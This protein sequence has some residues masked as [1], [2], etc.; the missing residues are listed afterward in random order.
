MVIELTHMAPTGEAIGKHDGQVIFVPYGVPGDVIEI[1]IFHKRRNFARARITEILRPSSHRVIPPCRFFGSCGGCEWQH[2]DYEQQLIYKANAVKEQFTRIG[3][4]P[5]VTV[6]PCIPSPTVW[7]YRNHTQF[8]LSHWRK[9]GYRR[10]NTNTVVEVDHCHV[11]APKL[12]ELLAQQIQGSVFNDSTS[13]LRFD[14]RNEIHLRTGARTDEVTWFVTSE[15]GKLLNAGEKA[16]IHEQI[17]N[18]VFRIS[19][20]SFFQINTPMAEILV[21][22]ILNKLEVNENHNVL[23][24]YCGVGLFTVPIAERVHSVMGIESNP[25]STSDAVYNLRHVSNATVLTEDVGNALADFGSKKTWHAIV[26][27]PPRAGIEYAALKSIVALNAHQ[28]IYVSCD[29]AT[30][31]RDSR[32]LCDRGYKLEH[33]QPFDMFPHTHHVETVAIFRRLSVA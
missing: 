4:L 14:D 28:L 5:D 2:V 19:P 31:A 18:A 21:A 25:S 32:I 22:T 8:V 7:N 3:K 13:Y 16:V 6:E 29:P 10:A 33:I 11:I 30:L 23:D 1:D 27:D 26:I 12:N 15:A 17:G 20:D 9:P 24:L